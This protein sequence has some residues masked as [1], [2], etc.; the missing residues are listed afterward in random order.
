[1]RGGFLYLFSYLTAHPHKRKYLR[2]LFIQNEQNVL[3]FS[4]VPFSTDSPF[5]VQERLQKDLC[6][7]L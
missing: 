6:V 4:Y 5:S 3:K 7:V 2:L 1:M